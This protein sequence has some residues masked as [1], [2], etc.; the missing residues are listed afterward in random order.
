M[1]VPTCKSALVRRTIIR[2]DSFG[3]LKSGSC[4]TFRSSS[5][6]SVRGSD[7]LIRND[8]RVFNNDAGNRVS[9]ALGEGTLSDPGSSR[10]RLLNMVMVVDKP[11]L[12]FEC[13]S[14]SRRSRVDCVCISDWNCAVGCMWRAD[15]RWK[16]MRLGT[17]GLASRPKR[18]M[19]V[20][21]S[22]RLNLRCGRYRHF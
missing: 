8:F 11:A 17:E 9:H 13:L 22:E 3:S 19:R 12:A 6:C 7:G 14:D 16:L 18:A 1:T 15:E 4:A 10:E 20:I 2:D 5:A 21:R